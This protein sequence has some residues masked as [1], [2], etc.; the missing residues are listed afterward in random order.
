MTAYEKIFF[1]DLSKKG[2][3]PPNSLAMQDYRKDCVAVATA[4]KGAAV[5]WR[6]AE[7]GAGYEAGQSPVTAIQP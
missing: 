7:Y 6:S 2:L 3:T 4:S 1:T 5:D